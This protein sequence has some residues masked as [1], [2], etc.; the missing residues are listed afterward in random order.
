VTEIAPGAAP[1]PHTLEYI[2][3]F[4]IAAGNPYKPGT[5]QFDDYQAGLDDAMKAGRDCDKMDTCGSSFSSIIRF[6]NS[7]AIIFC[8]CTYSK[9]APT[10]HRPFWEYNFASQLFHFGRIFFN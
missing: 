6:K 3:A 7:K 4:N 8:I 2:Q 5:K 1:G 9:I 10:W